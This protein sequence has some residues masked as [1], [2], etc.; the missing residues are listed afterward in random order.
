MVV[1]DHRFELPLDHSQAGGETITVFAREVVAVQRANE[2]LPWLLFLQ[3][4][5]GYE[6]PR[7]PTAVPWLPAA[8]NEYRV[9]LLDQRGTGLSTRIDGDTL[10]GLSPT[11]QAHRLGLHRADAIV[12]DCEAIRHLLLGHEPWTVLGQSYGGFCIL[13]YLS[14]S[15]SGLAGALI[16][17]GLAPLHGH[18]DA[19]YRKT[20]AQCRKK[21]RL[22]YQRYPD[23]VEHVR[24][25]ASYLAEKTVD[26]PSGGLLTVRRFQQLGLA[27]GTSSGFESLHALVE[28]AF[29]HTARGEQLGFHFL[30]AVDQALSYPTHPL[31]SLL[32]ESIY[33]QGS[34]S[35]W[36]AQRMLQEFPEFDGLRPGQPLLFTGEM[37]YPWMFDEIERLAPLGGA[38]EI[39][40]AREDW[41]PLYDVEQLS[42][43]TVPVVAAVYHD[44]MFVDRE[45]SLETADAVANLRVWI[46]NEFEHDGL[47][48]S[49]E[50]VFTHLASMLHGLAY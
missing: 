19:V 41:P 12:H 28:D 34:A 48:S 27:L 3:G 24:R 6:S 39:L 9:L 18:P 31:Y 29:V 37:I 10:A 16:T 30:S 49:G 45:L 1:S 36:S 21:N 47:R 26:L 44:D 14:V 25:I 17:G 35:R 20:Y 2:N 5:P 43:N 13:R 33:C 7:S 15:P 32:H 40:A 22:Y 46:T 50:R 38:A 4:G 42:K 8:L 23:D 11:E